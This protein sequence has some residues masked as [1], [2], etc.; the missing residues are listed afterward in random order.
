M[1]KPQQFLELGK[2]K[3]THYIQP[4][5]LGLH[6]S[7]SGESPTRRCSLQLVW[8]WH[9]LCA[10]AVLTSCSILCSCACWYHWNADSLLGLGCRGRSWG[11]ERP[12]VLGAAGIGWGK[13]LRRSIGAHSPFWGMQKER[14]FWAGCKSA[15]CWQSD[16]QEE[17]LALKLWRGKICSQP[18][19]WYQRNVFSEDKRNRSSLPSELSAVPIRAVRAQIP[20]A[21]KRIPSWGGIAAR[22]AC[23]AAGTP[24]AQPAPLLLRAATGQS[25]RHTGLTVTPYLRAMPC[26]VSPALSRC[27]T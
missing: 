19:R 2:G 4:T 17:H 7:S 5:N 23:R 15:L 6:C 22:G 20:P 24:K 13:P 8:K 10:R 21:G 1:L 14:R 16:E 26:S 27:S 9:L 3:E 18:T 11:R 12:A 25:R